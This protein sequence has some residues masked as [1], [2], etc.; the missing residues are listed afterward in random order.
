MPS[1]II[2]LTSAAAA[3]AAALAQTSLSALVKSGRLS[4]SVPS[5]SKSSR[6]F[7]LRQALRC[8]ATFRNN[9]CVGR[10]PAAPDCRRPL[11]W[12]A[13]AL[14][15]PARFAAIILAAGEGTRMQSAMPKVMHEVAGRPMIAH[16]LAA[17][18]PLAPAATVVVIGPRMAGRRQRGRAGRSV[19]QDP[20]LGTGDAV[21]AGARRARRPPCAGER[22]RRSAGAVRRHAAAHDRDVGAAAGAAPRDGGGDRCGRHAPRRSR[23][24]WP[25]CAR[26]RTARSSASSRRTTRPPKSAAIALCNGGD[27]GGRRRAC[28]RPCRPRS[29]AT[30][31]SANST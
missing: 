3:A 11:V 2:G 13:R 7:S 19:V 9:L 30:T 1:P 6:N 31:P 14:D 24:L 16:L 25:A 8:C 15:E 21:R 23:P 22:D 17:L 26:R 10:R 5:R 18:E 12:C 28:R 29:T 20:P 27:H 4:T